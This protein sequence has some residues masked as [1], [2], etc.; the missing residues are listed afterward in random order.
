MENEKFKNLYQSFTGQIDYCNLIESYGED[1]VDF[2]DTNFDLL[3]AQFC[4]FYLTLLLDEYLIKIDDK[5]YTT[6]FIPKFIEKIVE[7]IAIDNGKGYT[8]GDLSYHDATTILVKLRHKLAH[9]DFIIK[10]NNIVFEENKTEGRINLDLLKKALLSFE[11]SYEDYFLTKPRCK[12]FNCARLPEGFININTESDFDKAC[13]NIYRLEITDTPISKTGRNAKYV[14][15]MDQLYKEIVRLIEKD[16]SHKI[17][18]LIFQNQKILID[19]GIKLEYSF[20]RLPITEC[21]NNTKEKYMANFEEYKL[22]PAAEQLNLI[23]NLSY[24]INK[25]KYQKFNIRKGLLLN[26]FLLNEFKK[27]PNY[28]LK[29][30]IENNYELCNLFIYHLDDIIISSYL[31]AFNSLYEYGLETEATKKGYTNFVKIYEGKQLDFSKLDL[32]KLDDPKMT[33]EHDCDNFTTDVLEYEKD[34]II[35][36]DKQIASRNRNLKS[37]LE[38]CRNQQESKINSLTTEVEK[39]KQEKEVLLSKI[40]D[41]KVSLMTYD[42]EKYIKNINIIYHIRNAIAHGNIFVDSY[43]NDIQETNV[44]IRNYHEGKICYEKKLKIKDFVTLFSIPNIEVCYEFITN[45]V[46][47]KN[48]IINDYIDSLTVRTILKMGRNLKKR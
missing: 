6:E 17:P 21:Y 44:I 43:S 31:V 20:R 15:I 39:V 3:Q 29:K 47:D 26:I 7:I 25:G 2:T 14:I 5:N 13:N 1:F 40:D 35:E 16:N 28:T 19:N 23:N 10:D 32:D 38:N 4:G 30:V 24:R 46:I 18:E 42:R 12:A 41:I 45:N 8:V 34:S 33:I 11:D 37:Y 36:I 48:V 27:N 22:L 9:G